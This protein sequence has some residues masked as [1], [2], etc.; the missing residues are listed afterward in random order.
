M[1]GGVVV[2]DVDQFRQQYPAVT[3]NDEQ[4]EGY[5]M[6]S[7][8]MLNNTRCSVVKDL[9]QRRQ[10]LYMLTAHIATI[11]ASMDSGNPLV[12][13]VSSATEG[14]VSISVDYGQ[15]GNNE[16]WYL[17]TPYGAMYWQLTAKYRSALYRLGKSPMPV[18]RRY[19]P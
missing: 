7:E 12:G 9:N 15:M 17:Q 18:S 2:F 14:T 13:R 3:A 5:F 19:F 8:S 6:L 1:S 4:L 11:N 16:R 10:L